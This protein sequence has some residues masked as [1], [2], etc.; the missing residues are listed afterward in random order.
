MTH[1]GSPEEWVDLIETQLPD[2][3]DLV[4]E[5]WE[6]MPPP[7]ANEREDPLSESLC[8]AL[9]SSR[10]RCDLPFRIDTQLV[11]L[12]PAAGQDQGRM[13]IVFSPPVPREDIYFCLECKRVNVRGGDGVRPYFAEYVRFGMLRF[14][15][16]QYANSVRNGGMLAFVLNGDVASA[17]AGV[18]ENVRQ[19]QGDLGMD[20]PGAFLISAIR[21]ADVRL[22]ETR[23][24]RDN[25]PDPFII[26]HLFM[27]GD[28]T[29]PLRPDPPP[30]PPAK[31][32]TPRKSRKSTLRGTNE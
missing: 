11:E 8:R 16:G 3:I 30:K 24:R 18:E 19:L 21:P 2:I 14:V 4:I 31:P 32:R 12:D 10:N 5:T 20:V 17:I 7:A 9:R 1:V 27:A 26:H 13:D 28:P 6:G 25:R 15:R 29:A 23:H 22:R